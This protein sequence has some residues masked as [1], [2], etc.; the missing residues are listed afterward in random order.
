M[1]P[2][3]GLSRHLGRKRGKTVRYQ[4]TI[5]DALSYHLVALFGSLGF[6]DPRGLI[7][8]IVGNLAKTGGSRDDIRYTANMCAHAENG[9]VS[10]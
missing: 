8:V 9:V 3:S 4:T 1:Y 7:P 6:V 5:W 2:I 10:N